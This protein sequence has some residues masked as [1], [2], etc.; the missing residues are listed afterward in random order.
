VN[1]VAAQFA[2]LRYFI[3]D[4]TG[5]P[6]R[7]AQVGMVRRSVLRRDDH[8]ADERLRRTIARTNLA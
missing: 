5:Q 3:P 8:A 6:G 2:A 1:R 7:K 4:G